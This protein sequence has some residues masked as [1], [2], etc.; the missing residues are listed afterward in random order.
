MH[1]RRA[2]LYV[3]GDDRRKIDLG[4]ICQTIDKIAFIFRK[5][6]NKP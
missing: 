4:Q 1:P 5:W 6:E 3:P 2:L